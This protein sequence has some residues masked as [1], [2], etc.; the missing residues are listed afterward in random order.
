MTLKD[1]HNL[2]EI[3]KSD[4]DLLAKSPLHFKRKQELKSEPTPA[5]MLGTLAHKLILEPDDFKNEFLIEPVCDKRTKEGKAIYAELMANLGDKI[6]ITQE[7]FNT[8][9]AIANAVLKTP[10]AKV[11]LKDGL[12]EQVYFGEIDGVAVKA[13]PDFYNENLGVIV[14]LKTTSDASASG[15]AK[16]V[17]NFNYH[18]QTAFYS[19]ILRQNGKAVNNF[20]F[21]AVETKPPYF[22]GFYELDDEAI[23][24]AQSRI[25]ELLSLYRFCRDNDKWW[26]YAKKID[27][28]INHIVKIGL[29]AYKFYEA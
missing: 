1:Y 11:F 3:S 8:A 14:D 2:S 10:Q 25:L 28:K 20:L 7:Q 18:I 17:A 19:E 15:F 27:D 21:V 24:L 23:N 12:A 5:L 4:L 13:K 22:V 9:Q 29:P 16:S 6:A 26:G